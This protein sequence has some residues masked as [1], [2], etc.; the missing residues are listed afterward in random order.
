[1]SPIVVDASI[2][3]DW[4]LGDEFDPRARVCL[5]APGLSNRAANS[6]LQEAN[7]EVASDL[8]REHP[9]SF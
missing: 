1:M 8:A 7:L 4:L 3:A 5:G 2:A 9:L 6:H